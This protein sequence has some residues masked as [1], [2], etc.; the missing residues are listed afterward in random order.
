MTNTSPGLTAALSLKNGE[1]DTD[2]SFSFSKEKVGLRLFCVFA[3]LFAACT[4]HPAK[5]DADTILPDIETP[6][7]GDDLAVVDDAV[8]VADEDTVE[9]EA[10]ELL[11]D[12]DT[13]DC[14]PLATAPFPYY[15]EDGTIHFCRPCDTPTEK[16]PQC[17]RNL[18]EEENK[19]LTKD[20]PEYDCYPYPCVMPNLKPMTKAEV[21][22]AFQ[23]YSIHECD[24]KLENVGWYQDG[25][26]G[27]VKHWNLSGGIVG[28]HM[29]PVTIAP[30]DY[31]TG[32]KAFVYDIDRKSYL[33]LGPM[34]A[35]MLSYR[36]G[37]MIMFSADFRSLELG[38]AHQ[39]VGYYGIDG[40]YRIV[41]PKPIHFIAYTPAN[42]ENWVF[43]NI[44]ETDGGP[45]RMMYAKVD[46]WE[47]TSLGE[48]MA[49]MPEFMGNKLALYLGDDGYVCDLTKSPQSLSSCYSVNR[50]NEKVAEVHFDRQVADGSVFIYTS[51]YSR[52][53][54]R[55]DTNGRIPVYEDIITDFSPDNNTYPFSLVAERADGNTILYHE[56]TGGDGSSSRACFYRL[57][58]KK[59]YYMKMVDRD[60]TY[61]YGY[62]EFEG[63]WFLYQRH[64]GTPALVLR[65]LDCYC[66]KESVCP[67]EGLK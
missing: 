52:A 33:A 5:T 47:W 55:V 40:S 42:N 62:A 13:I 2:R 48:G 26:S 7:V 12:V 16:D 10:D 30:A 54:V 38:I 18:W 4:S 51:D 6:T 61:N 49:L 59:K 31:M 65:D 67:F 20:H 27:S 45:Y 66:E 46:E 50:E 34:T 8:A 9:V 3:L 21:D 28:F 43:A 39:Y 35:D 37:K 32:N 36:Q 58:T 25:T 57:D 22:V 29:T 11:S 60:S 1:G 23:T 63:K 19:K 14:P 15:K 44:Q 56:V 41:Y 17:M 64:T 53:I 24:L